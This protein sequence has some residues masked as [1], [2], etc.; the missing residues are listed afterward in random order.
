MNLW[1]VENL[2]QKF[3]LIEKHQQ[4]ELKRD[5]KKVEDKEI[6]AAAARKKALELKKRAEAERVRLEAKAKGKEIA[7][8][9]ITRQVKEKGFDVIEEDYKLII[10]CKVKFKDGT[11]EFIN[12]S[13]K[14]LDELAEVLKKIQPAHNNCRSHR[15]KGQTGR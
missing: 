6:T 1:Q 11:S 8:S 4:Y 3:L 9:I 5:K 7:L 2:F 10:N 15:F 14:N 12:G 13:Q